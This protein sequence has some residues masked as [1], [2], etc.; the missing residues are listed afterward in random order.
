MVLLII[1]VRRSLILSRKVY[2]IAG[3]IAEEVLYNIKTVVSFSN[4]EF[5]KERFNTHIDRVHELHKEGAFRFAACT[6]GVMFF[7]FF[8]FVV[9]LLYSKRLL[10]NRA[11]NSNTGELFKSGDIMTV[12]M[13]TT[14]AIMLIG[15]IAP[16]I[17]IIQEACVAASDYFT[18]YKRVPKIDEKDSNY[19]PQ[20]NLVKGKIE[21]M[22]ITFIYPLDEKKKKILNG[23][24]FM[25]E[26]G[27]KVALVG[28]SGCGKSTTV[29][30][31]ERLYNITDGE[32]LID[33]VD[34][35]KY[36]LKYLRTLI[37]YV[38]Q[39]PVLFNKSI[40]ENLLF[41]REE[42]IKA[43]FGNDI[44]TLIKNDVRNHTQENS[45]KKIQKNMTTQYV[46]K[47]VNFQVDKSKEL[48]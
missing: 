19:K 3:G 1:T 39:K 33:D 46:L 25:F 11:Y 47:E 23:L 4:F 36:N 14:M 20:R 35:R 40:R 18:L 30:L 44:D 34:I 13:A 17:M 43:E 24:N 22:N 15:V 27:K 8:T 29:N 7:L 21:F 31:I 45:L 6:G 9:G 37:G 28:E 42:A 32:V 26:P 41:G 38:Q 5:E 12:N 10:I 16:N 48:Q 2:E